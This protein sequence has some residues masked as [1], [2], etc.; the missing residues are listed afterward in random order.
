M[1]N[2]KSTLVLNRSELSKLMTIKDYIIGIEDAFR[3]HGNGETY[4]T[5]LIHGDTPGELEFHIKAGGLKVGG[6]Y[7]YGLKI[8]SSCFT[9]MEQFGL[10][11]IMGAILLFD[12]VKGLPLAI[13]DSI[14]P[15][16]K[17]TGAGTA[18][19][20]KYL[21]KSNSSILT[22]CGCGNQGRIQLEALKEILP[23]DGVFAFDQKDTQ[24]QTFTREM[25]QKLSINIEVTK[26]LAN[27]AANS[28]IV[29]TCTPSKSPFLKMQFIQP[30]TLVASIGSDSPDKQ[31]LESTLM[32]GTKVVV[33]ILEQCALVGELHH[34]L[35]QKILSIEQ[36]H[37]EI[38][39]VISGKKTGRE[40]DQEIIIYDATGTA[41]QDTAAAAICYEKAIKRG[42]GRYI[43][44]SG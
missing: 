27:A 22:I 24:A 20:A 40:S 4:G 41:I 28:D 1:N 25:S 6:N 8:N 38:G 15:T 32:A 11:N 23:I 34:A 10:P 39:E 29:V 17:R 37:A 43:N 12:S 5:D 2:T 21:A 26:D 14:E 7:Y 13:I 18:V 16:I 42:A 36:V 35:K 44:L 9:N 3:M 30:G 33:D 31:E 19:A